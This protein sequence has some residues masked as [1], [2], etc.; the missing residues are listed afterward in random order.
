MRQARRTLG[1]AYTLGTAS[2][3]DAADDVLRLRLLVESNSARASSSGRPWP[4][5]VGVTLAC[6]G[7]VTR[8]LVPP[9]ASLWRTGVLRLSG[10]LRVLLLPWLLPPLRRS[11]VRRRPHGPV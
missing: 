2:I 5:A 8:V 11:C 9:R 7:L 10:F 1:W 6:D 4:I 3:A